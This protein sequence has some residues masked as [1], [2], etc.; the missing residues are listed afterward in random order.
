[1]AWD[2][3][4][5]LD[6]Q[7]LVARRN[8]KWTRYD[9]DILPA[10]VAEMDFAI[11]PPIQHAI[12]QIV[13]QQQYGYPGGAAGAATVQV[14]Q[15]FA[16][17][18][19]SHFS[20]SLD[21]STAIAVADLVQGTYATVMAFSDS[22]ESILLQTPAYPPFFDAIATSGRKAIPWAFEKSETTHILNLDALP[23]SAS[24]AK[25]LVL[26]NPHNPTGR[27]LKRDELTRIANYAIEKDMIVVS[28]EI[29]ADIVYAGSKHIP[30]ASLGADIAARTITLNSA[31]KSFNIPGLRCAV[32]HFGSRELMNRFHR[33]FPPKLLGACSGISMAATVAAWS[34]GQEWLDE[35]MIRLSTARD[36]MIA[37]FHNEFPEIQ[38]TKPEGTY[39]GW[40]DCSALPFN[41]SAFDFFK[42]HA[43]VALSPGESFSP[44]AARYVRI[45]FATSLPILDEILGRMGSAIR[46]LQNR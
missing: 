8:A 29:H 31:T 32:I 20:W 28:D 42:S 25:L 12:E 17:R 26:C 44:E 34:E 16:K 4:F 5:E 7:T 22:G 9:P 37:F 23:D 38:V 3:L 19:Q 46:Q 1:M 13:G 30:F 10:F 11:A 35:A 43:K 21:P 2:N 18:M 45:N 15:A 6:K 33:R 39:F 41:D 27:V 24:K 36:R 14:T 40:L